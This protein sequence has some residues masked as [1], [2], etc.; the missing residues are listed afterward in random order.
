[1][2]LVWILTGGNIDSEHREIKRYC[3]ITYD[4]LERRI[5]ISNISRLIYFPD[6]KTIDENILKKIQDE[7]DMGTFFLSKLDIY[8]NGQKY[9]KFGYY[10][11]LENEYIH[12]EIKDP[13]NFIYN[14]FIN[15]LVNNSVLEM[16]Y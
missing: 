8:C 16:S 12:V 11:K 5:K 4:K 15:L 3:L 13:L 10:G 1:M 9:F 7:M 2:E 14:Q 6:N